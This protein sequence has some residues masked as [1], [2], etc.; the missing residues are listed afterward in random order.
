M[1]EDFGGRVYEVYEDSIKKASDNGS[2]AVAVDLFELTKSINMLGFGRTGH[3]GAIEGH[4]IK[5]AEALGTLSASVDAVASAIAD[6]ITIEERPYQ[7]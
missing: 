3:V 7:K 6:V 4:T 2:Y 5:M 1:S